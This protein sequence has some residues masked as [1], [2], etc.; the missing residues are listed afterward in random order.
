MGRYYVW[1]L[2][3]GGWGSWN[4]C[5]VQII[6]GRSNSWGLPPLLPPPFLSFP[7]SLIRIRL[8]LFS[9]PFCYVSSFISNNRTLHLL[10]RLSKL[11]QFLSYKFV[12]FVETY[13]WLVFFLFFSNIWTVGW[14]MLYYILRVN[15]LIKVAVSLYY[16]SVLCSL[17]TGS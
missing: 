3:K 6:F 5:L 8:Y 2:L 17:N 11:L 15:G 13:E 16:I 4:D 14:I 12:H 9:L 7:P 10:F 1:G